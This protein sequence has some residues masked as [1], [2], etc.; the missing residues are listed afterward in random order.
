MRRRTWATKNPQSE[1][2]HWMDQEARKE[3]DD[4]MTDDEPTTP[5]PEPEATRQEATVIGRGTRFCPDHQALEGIC[6]CNQ[7]QQPAESS[8]GERPTAEEC[9]KVIALHEK[10]TPGPWH[11]ATNP[12]GPGEQPAFPSVRDD[13]WALHGED[14]V[15]MPLGDSETV[16]SNADFIAF[17]RTFAPK[18]A[19]AL[20]ATRAENA[21]QAAEIERLK[22]ERDERDSLIAKDSFYEDRI[23]DIAH[24]LAQELEEAELDPNDFV[25]VNRAKLNDIAK[26]I[27]E[28]Q[29]ARLTSELAAAKRDGEATTQLLLRLYRVSRVCM[30][31]GSVHK[32]QDEAMAEYGHDL[33]PKIEQIITARKAQP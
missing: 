11:R 29:D 19:L 5:D 12:G 2:D 26:R 17:A 28:K 1:Y 6:G 14:I 18:A 33:S 16:K 31:A 8:A 22:Q 7:P 4:E 10:A 32:A 13:T 27:F 24:A 15:A 9:A 3:P 21:R 25:T 20:T 23:E 30:V